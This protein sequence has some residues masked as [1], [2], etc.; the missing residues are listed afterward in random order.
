MAKKA[1]LSTHVS[2]PASSPVEAPLPQAPQEYRNPRRSR[3]GKRP[4]MFWVDADDYHA[5][6]VA[7]RDRRM[8]IQSAGEE[9]F[10]AFARENNIPRPSLSRIEGNN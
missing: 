1:I 3:E 8:T 9:M 2:T 7:L 10:N 5:F 4:V 6:A